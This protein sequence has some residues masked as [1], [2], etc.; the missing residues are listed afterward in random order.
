VTFI[1]CFV[2]HGNSPNGTTVIAGHSRRMRCIAWNGP[3]IVAR[4]G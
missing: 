1:P 3:P 2:G 4:S